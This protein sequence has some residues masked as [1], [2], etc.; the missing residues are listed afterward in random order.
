MS[1]KR[2]HAVAKA[3]SCLAIAF[4]ASGSAMATNVFK[5]EGFGPISR[6]MGGTGAAHDIGAAAMM[7]NPATL[8]LI[9]KGAELHLG[10]DL[11][12]T[13]IDTKNLAT[14]E[15]ASSD[16]RSNNRGPY[17]APEAAFTSRQGQFTFGV[18]AFAEGGLGTEYGSNSFLSRTTTNN[19]DTGL[20][21]SSRLLVLRIPLAAAFQINDRLTVG[22]SLDAVWTALNLGLLL[23]VTQIGALAAD[24][25]ISGS[26]VPVLLAV[27]GL[28]GGHFSFTK[29][30]IVGGG[31]DAWGV[32]G[33]L[34]LTYQVSP[35]TRIGAAY[36]FKTN[37]SDLKG[38]AILT[39]VSAVAGNI[40]LAGEIKIRDFEMPAQASLGI[41]HRFSDKLT[42]AA[43][44][45]RVFWKDVMKNID[46]GF[47]ADGSGANIDILLPQ[48]Y[49][50]INVYAIGAEYRY[51]DKWTFRGGAGYANQAVPNN[52]LFAIVPG[53]LTTHVTGGL[54]YAFDRNK[55]LDFALSFALRKSLSNS[56]QPNTS[57][58]IEGTHSQVNAV[59]GYVY[60][61]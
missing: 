39:A 24:N 48:N 47:V 10:L 57:V 51:S 49:R 44:Y 56:S 23:D 13:N 11:V 54:S 27:P 1:I 9:N 30:E 6:A 25:R 18:G 3:L 42:V 17:Y 26:L 46:V 15:N 4:S 52:M 60:G 7:Y 21:N 38:R 32:G 19:I 8:G 53:I 50:D 35:E 5:M 22:G 37:V 36:N 58:P 59:I 29:N 40:P 31:T 14:G 28:S 61:F 34:G 55:R 2:M 43:D 41:S 16:N 20:D 12:N 33:K 45:Q